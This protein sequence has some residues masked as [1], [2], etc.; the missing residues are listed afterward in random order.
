ML[1]HL[2]VYSLIIT[3]FCFWSFKTNI[4]LS[5]VWIVFLFSLFLFCILLFWS[6]LNKLLYKLHLQALFF[7][8]SSL[9]VQSPGV[10]SQLLFD[11]LY[12]IKAK[13]VKKA[14]QFL[15]LYHLC[16]TS[17]CCLCHRY[18]CFL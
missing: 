2:S 12:T 11:R 14:G 13:R 4:S 10:F 9:T 17:E 15:A 7:C 18:R 6:E 8:L 1:L 3:S 5:K 16:S